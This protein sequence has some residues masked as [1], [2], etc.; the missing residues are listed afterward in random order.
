[1]IVL[2]HSTVLFLYWPGST[3]LLWSQWL[4]ALWT[5]SPPYTVC[6][7][8]K[9]ES[10]AFLTWLSVFLLGLSH[11][12]T[13]NADSNVRRNIV[14]L[15]YCMHGHIKP[16]AVEVF[17]LHNKE[18]HR[19]FSEETDKQTIA[20]ELQSQYW[21]SIKSDVQLFLICSRKKKTRTSFWHCRLRVSHPPAY[22]PAN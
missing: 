19:C 15:I 13:I 2:H 5:P 3:S 4:D 11:V 17:M 21:C 9:Q 10:D 7:K 20:R 12:G 1:M 18:P 14:T 16:L 6:G 8:K 22:S